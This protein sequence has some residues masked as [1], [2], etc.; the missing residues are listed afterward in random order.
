MVSSNM[1]SETK[2]ALECD[3]KGG[4]KHLSGPAKACGGT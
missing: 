2:V 3:L 4:S 1:R